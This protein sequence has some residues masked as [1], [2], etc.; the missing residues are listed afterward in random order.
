MEYDKR[1]VDAWGKRK[2][3]YDEGKK[4]YDKGNK[5]YDKGDKLRNDSNNLYEEGNDLY[6][7]GDNIWSNAITEVHGNISIEWEDDKCI[8]ETGGIYRDW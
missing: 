7:E 8:L 6:D 5:L 4:L 2:E 3:L 1:L